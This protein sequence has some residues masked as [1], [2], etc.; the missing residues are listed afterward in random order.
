S[1]AE[2][3]EESSRVQE[4]M[5]QQKLK[6][7]AQRRQDTAQS[8]LKLDP[9]LAEGR[10]DFVEGDSSLSPWLPR[11]PTG[12]M[13]RNRDGFKGYPLEVGLGLPLGFDNPGVFGVDSKSE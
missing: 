1:Y 10:R 5:C 4:A 7:E 6:A 8:N 2:F 13:G 12:S 3:A 9:F 11:L